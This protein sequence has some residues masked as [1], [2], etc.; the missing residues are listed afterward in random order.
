[1]LTLSIIALVIGTLLLILALRGRVVERGAFC[2]KCRFNLAGLPAGQ[3]EARCPEC[4][5]DLARP[6]ATRPTLRRRKPVL[7]VFAVMLLLS[8]TTLLGIIASNNTA[9]V[10]AALPDPAVLTMHDLGVDAAFTEIVTNRL[11]QPKPLSNETWDRLIA[12]AIAHQRN[13][14]ETWDPRH[15]EV[16]LRAF[17]TGR[18]NDEQIEQYFELGFENTVEISDEIRYGTEEV[19][20]SVARSSTGRISAMSSNF[21]LLTDPI[22]EVWNRIEIT[23]AGMVEPRYTS[24]DSSTGWT[25]LSI[26]GPVGG[27]GRGSIGG[28]IPMQD[29]D[30]STIE[31][32]REYEFFVEYDIRVARMDDNYVH[33]RTQ[34]RVTRQVRVLPPETDLVKLIA[35]PEHI[36]K[37]RDSPTLRL[38][39]LR[40]VPRSEQELL[41]GGPRSLRIGFIAVELPVAVVGQ[42]V[43]IHNGE[44]FPI[45]EVSMTSL[46]GHLI[47]SIDRTTTQGADDATVQQW[48]DAGQVTIEIRPDPRLAERSPGVDRILGVPLRFEGVPVTE[49]DISPTYNSMPNPMPNPLHTPGRPVVDPAHEPTA[50]EG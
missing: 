15:G 46:G 34:Q 49:E 22:G 38:S 45:G 1:M 12:D 28:T 50:D 4:G 42:V 44:E 39:P 37:F 10:M 47:S 43:V 33:Y 18:L 9:R 11:A 14:T 40:I 35:D 20:V 48:L 5:A 6:N 25:G 32:G 41:K 7:L 19:G 26:P 30:W 27:G 3:D 13:I 24:N 36:D 21:G 29:F 8:A 17:M 31:P 23:S 16:L 2:R